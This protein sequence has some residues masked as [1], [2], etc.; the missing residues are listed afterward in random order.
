[1]NPHAL[2]YGPAYLDRVLIV[3]RPLAGGR[4]IDRSVSGLLVEAPTSSPADALVLIDPEAGAVPIVVPSGWPGPFGAIALSSPV[5]D[6][7]TGGTGLVGSSWRDDLGG[8]GAGFAS[9]LSGR[10]VCSLGAV[11][12]PI[13][14]AVARLLKT[15]GV[16][17]DPIRVEGEPGDWTLL[18]SSGPHGDKLAIG[19]RGGAAGWL[20]LIGAGPQTSG[21]V[22]VAG[23]ANRVA[24]RVL[25]GS[26][27]PRLL[28]PSM[29]SCRD[30]DVPLGDLAGLAEFFACN[31][32]EWESLDNL[33]RTA[34][35]TRLDLLAVTDG[36]RG[37][38]L[39]F[40]KGSAGYELQVPAFPRSSPPVD[41]NRA[42]EAFASTLVASLIVEGWRPGDPPPARPV[43]ESLGRR[44]SAASALVLDRA[45]FG[46]PEAAEIE[47][48]LAEDIVGRTSP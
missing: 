1:M 27:P 14:D 46:F 6:P 26:R 13:A 30:R 42:G 40:G 15:A 3:D 24:G 23:L 29:R 16:D 35:E 47:R 11:G 32:G 2:V 9:A 45:G 38:R 48:A 5:F 44:A 4:S 33:T 43:A 20:D 8:M 37:A 10:L 17:S 21:L 18:L 7:A 19:L 41:T 39:R 31:R 22:V 25:R 28:A 12:D 34:W 36:P